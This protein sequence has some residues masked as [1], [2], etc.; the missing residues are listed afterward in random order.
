M[1]LIMAFD[2]PDSA[3]LRL[4]TR[5]AHVEYVLGQGGMLLGGPFMS[6]DGE[7]MTGSMLILDTQDRSVAEAFVAGDPYN[8]AGLFDK[9]EI[10][11]WSHLIGGLSDPNSTASN[12]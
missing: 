9:V 8:K 12:G 7:T 10:R 6:D 3:A 4:E 11:R 5:P 1:Y 2:K